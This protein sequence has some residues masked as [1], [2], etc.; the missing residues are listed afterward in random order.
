MRKFAT[1]ISKDALKNQIY[2]TSNPKKGIVAKRK[3][4]YFVSSQQKELGEDI[5]NKKQYIVSKQTPQE[6]T[7]SALFVMSD[8]ERQRLV[9]KTFEEIDR[10]YGKALRNLAK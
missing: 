9:D 1:K 6:A 5:P 3:G 2:I 8:P 4:T 7:D 10:K